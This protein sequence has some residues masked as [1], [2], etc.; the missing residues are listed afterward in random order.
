MSKRVNNKRRRNIRRRLSRNVTGRHTQ[1]RCPSR[2]HESDTALRS[3]HDLI[4]RMNFTPDW[5][6][7]M[8]P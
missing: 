2:Y 1:L 4:G 8:K 3:I 7:E 6:P 5:V